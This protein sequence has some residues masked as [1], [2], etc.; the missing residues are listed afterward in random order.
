[1]TMADDRQEQQGDTPEDVTKPLTT[2]EA[3]EQGEQQQ[4]EINE[5]KEESG[6]DQAV[7]FVPGEAPPT[8]SPENPPQPPQTEEEADELANREEDE[9]ATD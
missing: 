6:I 4:R 9:Q 7:P 2:E 1:M 8:S 5:Q 3:R